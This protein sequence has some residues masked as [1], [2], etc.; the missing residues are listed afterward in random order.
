MFIKKDVLYKHQQTQTPHSQ[1][2]DKMS[3]YSHQKKC[4]QLNPQ[5]IRRREIVTGRKQR[6]EK[7]VITIKK[8][9]IVTQKQNGMQREQKKRKVAPFRNGGKYEYENSK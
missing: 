3:Y 1:E 5:N 6:V 4:T 7:A 9:E 8:Q 2:E